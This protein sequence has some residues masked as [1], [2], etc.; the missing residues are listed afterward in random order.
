M[1]DALMDSLRQAIL[2]I[3]PPSGKTNKYSIVRGSLKKYKGSLVVF[4][5]ITKEF[6]YY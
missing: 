2:R 6:N 1:S 5:E 3:Q 4:N